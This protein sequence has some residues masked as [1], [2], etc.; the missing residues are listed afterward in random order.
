MISRTHSWIW[1]LP[2][3][4]FAI[5]IRFWSL[6]QPS[7]YVF[8]EVY[9]VPTARLI[10][11]GD[12]RAFEWWHMLP[13]EG[14]AI[15]W[16]HPPLAKYVQ[17]GFILFVGDNELGWR[18]PS[19]VA[20][21]LLVVAVYWVSLGILKKPSL[22]VLAAF[23]VSLDG[24]PLVMSRLTMNDIFVTVLMVMTVG[25]YWQFYTSR[26][27]SWL[28]GTGLLAGLSIA[29]KWSGVFVLIPVVLF[30]AWYFSNHRTLRQLARTVIVVG[31]VAVVIPSAVYLASYWPL[32]Y[33]SDPVSH[34]AELH[35]QILL[36]QTGLTASHDYQSVPWQWWLNLRPV[37]F[38]TDPMS[39]ADIYAQ[40][41]PVWHVWSVPAMMIAAGWWIAAGARGLEE[42]GRVGM[43]LL[44]SLSCW[45]VW[46]IS[47]RIMFYYHYLPAIPWL[48]INL[49]WVLS[50]PAFYSGRLTHRIL[51]VVIL[52]T[53][54]LGYVLW[55]PQW[56]GIS[57][58]EWWDWLFRIVPSWV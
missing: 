19:A 55:L 5:L 50:Q 8:D 38:W 54:V 45:V 30:E 20:G 47:P 35:R 4:L 48:S 44:A 36:Y 2:I 12:W 42:A 28:V 31:L 9:H 27:L 22:S 1:L 51:S 11:N 25:A 52:V 3:V 56:L 57:A 21:V 18:L 40:G 6:D 16:L 29:T 23:L 53:I 24:L 17:A 7:G 33:R 43:V 13:E 32:L 37:W 41:N 34:F 39:S 58:P 46:S 49:A 14:A 15:D 10:A 26:K